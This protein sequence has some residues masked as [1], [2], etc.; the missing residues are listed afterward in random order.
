M[1]QQLFGLQGSGM[2]NLF[3]VFENVSKKMGDKVESGELD[4]NK[5]QQTAQK[6]MQNLTLNNSD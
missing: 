5:L 1:F 4:I 2:S 3:N 6:M